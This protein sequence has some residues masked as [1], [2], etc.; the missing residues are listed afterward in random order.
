VHQAQVGRN[1]VTGGEQ[2]DVAGHQL[3][4]VELP[5]MP[6]PAHGDRR[7]DAACQGGQRPFRLG[8]LPVA[9]QRIDQYDAEDHPGID[10]LAQPGRHRAGR[11][12]DEDQR[13]RQLCREAPPGR[14][15]RPLG[16]PV[17][18]MLAQAFGG[19]AIVEARSVVDPQPAAGVVCRVGMP[20]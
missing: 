17:R 9:D 10:A 4:G 16:Q 2:H 8:F 7:G 15:A 18:A 1:T 14:L 5:A 12:E 6:A 13:L 19:F 3:A 11:D 20:G